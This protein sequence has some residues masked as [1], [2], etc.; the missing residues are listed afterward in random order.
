MNLNRMESGTSSALAS[1]AKQTSAAKKA[2]NFLNM[3]RFDS[4]EAS[5]PVAGT[6]LRPPTDGGVL[7]SNE[8]G[9]TNSRLL[10]LTV[11]PQQA[12]SH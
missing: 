3:V 2:S 6:Y 12:R 7:R 8:C 4:A 11:S 10:V 9:S 5:L 1:E